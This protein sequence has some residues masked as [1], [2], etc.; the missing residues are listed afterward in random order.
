MEKLKQK[1]ILILGI[2]IPL[3]LIIGFVVLFFTNKYDIVFNIED[4]K[5][6]K[7]EYEKNI[8]L[9]EVKATYEG[10]ILGFEN[11][12]VAVI[13]T[14]D[15][16]INDIGT[17]TLTYRAS[18]NGIEKSITVEVIV[19]DTSAPVIELVTTP[20]S[21]T[22]PAAKYEEEGYTATDNRDG[23]LTDSV[24]R[25]ESENEIKYTVTDK[26]GNTTTVIRPIVYK[27]VIAPVITLE[28]SADVTV[29]IGDAYAD[30]GYTAIDDVDGDITPA[31]TVEGT[32][33]TS[34]YGTYTLKYK[35][36][37]TSGNVAEITRNVKVADITAP[38]ITLNGSNSVYIKLGET[39]SDQGFTA[40]DNV[41][42]DL[43]DK[44]SISGDVNTGVAGNYSLTYEVTD[45]AGNV[46]KV[47]R[48]IYVFEKQASNVTVDPGN[49]IVYLTFDDGPGKHT[50]R[51]LDI[52]D[53]YG[54]KATFFVTNQHSGY[55][56]L[57][58]ETYRRGHTIALHTYSH[59]YSIYASEETYYADLQ[60]IQ[61]I[62]IEQTGVPAK[63]VRFPGGTSNTISENH[64]I[65][66]MS[67]IANGIGYRG[68]LYCDWNVSSGDAG[69][70]TTADG[71]ASNVISGMKKHKISY[72]LQHDTK[73]YSVDAVEQ[74]I[75]WGL[76]NGYT[77]L[78]LDETSP[79]YHH[80]PNN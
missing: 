69:G 78:P 66:I 70:T 14:G 3:I 18:H 45:S 23:D 72:V 5:T 56:N 50:A 59:N 37:D 77:F 64:C 51:L 6:I 27:D 47:T 67:T 35:V 42:G 17:Y 76:A 61:D 71:V 19:E 4:G 79:M 29:G 73:G 10:S 57:I 38:T 21:F 15:N 53:K 31:V 8:E 55:R 24:V 36:V 1:K 30:A 28:G 33:D 68:Y 62:V 52:L 26:A 39:Y 13:V 40:T 54:V 80:K 65:G 32:V 74:I 12:D 16:N 22:S 75:V 25:V 20:N 63:I 2:A 41:D 9:P 48:S 58:G 44:V 11:S 7:V 43:T 46:A 49:K 60:K 34:T